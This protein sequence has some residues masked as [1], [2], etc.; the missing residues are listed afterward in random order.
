M[1]KTRYVFPHVSLASVILFVVCGMSSQAKPAL[2]ATIAA[3]TGTVRVYVGTYTGHGSDGIYQF[4]LDLATG[5][6]TKPELAGEAVN[7]S[8]VALHP[9]GKFLYSV[10]EVSGDDGKKA[11]AIN[12]FAIDPA[13]GK[14]RLLNQQSSRGQGPCHVSVDHAGKFALTTNYN[15][16]SVAVLPIDADGSLSPASAFDQHAGSGPNPKRQEG[17][18]AHSANMDPTNQFAIVCDLGLDKIFVYRLGTDGSLTPNDPPTVSVAP[19]AGPRHFTFHPNGKIAYVIN[20]MGST[21]TAFNWDAAKGTLS[22]IQTISTLPDGMVMPGNTTAEVQLTPDGKYLYGSNRGHDTI[23]MFAVDP[24]TGKLTSLGEVPS[25]GK[26]PR[27]FA[28]DPTGTWL[29]AAHQNS[30]NI[31]I[32]HIDPATGKLEPTGDQVEVANPVC[33]KFYTPAK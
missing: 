32:F 13:T 18:H 8:F 6:P 33:V 14:L 21:I 26:T 19:G 17:P 27:N 11:G 29:V 20:E 23:A 5:K 16:G 9:S 3:P 10:S 31:C 30:K 7:P 1:R 28:I 15:S 25:G 22:E 2:A 24:A 12:A 4:D